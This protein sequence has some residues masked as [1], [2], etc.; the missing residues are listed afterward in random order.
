MIISNNFASSSMAM[1]QSMSMRFQASAVSKKSTA[2][3]QN[4]VGFVNKAS[5]FQVKKSESKQIGF[6]ATQFQAQNAVAGV[7]R[8]NS[9]SANWCISNHYDMEWHE[10]KPVLIELQQELNNTNFTGMTD[11]EIYD[12]IENRFIEVFGKDFLMAYNLGVLDPGSNNPN[13]VNAIINGTRNENGEIMS[14]NLFS[15]VLHRII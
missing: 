15:I 11:T 7:S 4:S 14:M 13:H 5:S 1:Q 12:Y 3:T 10:V 6:V 2:F 8:S 9:A